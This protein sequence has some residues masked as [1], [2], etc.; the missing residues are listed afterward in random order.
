M[1]AV[2]EGSV[3]AVA[4]VDVLHVAAAHGDDQAG[5]PFRSL[6]GDEL[7]NVVGHEHVSAKRAPLALQ[8]LAKPAQVGVIVRLVEDAG[9]AIVPPLHD[10]Q[11]NNVEM[12][13]V[14]AKAMGSREARR[15]GS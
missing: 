12:D 3:S 10:V 9:L 6:W 4:A 7:L 5:D 8:N 13:A 15:S 14:S 1:P 11:R 2:P